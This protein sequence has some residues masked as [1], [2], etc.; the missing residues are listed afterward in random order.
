MFRL[1]KFLAKSSSPKWDSAVFDGG[2]SLCVEVWKEFPV[3]LITWTGVEFDRKC[4]FV[5]FRLHSGWGCNRTIACGPQR[6]FRLIGGPFGSLV[7]GPSNKRG[8]FEDFRGRPRTEWIL[9]RAPTRVFILRKT[10][11]TNALYTLN[12]NASTWISV[13]MYA[14]FI[15][16]KI[17]ERGFWCVLNKHRNATICTREKYWRRLKCIRK[18]LKNL[19][20]LNCLTL[21]AEFDSKINTGGSI[22]LNAMFGRFCPTR[23]HNRFNRKCTRISNLSFVVWKSGTFVN[24]ANSKLVP[25]LRTFS[26]CIINRT[27]ETLE[28]RMSERP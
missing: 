6:A 11:H 14:S 17:F 16:W 25:N 12:G 2:Y 18:L 7:L 26:A 8:P 15:T 5:L 20:T 28:Q 4:G 9:N 22:Q 3:D 24:F 10:K 1:M 19:S 27:S 21:F 13:C 23:R